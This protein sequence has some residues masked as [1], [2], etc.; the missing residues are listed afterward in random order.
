MP[1]ARDAGLITKLCV[2]LVRREKRPKRHERLKSQLAINRGRVLGYPLKELPHM[3]R[4]EGISA[5][6]DL[7]NYAQWLAQGYE[8]AAE[9]E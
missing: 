2:S 9:A 6:R 3:R 8:S 1:K 5:R 7:R 4:A